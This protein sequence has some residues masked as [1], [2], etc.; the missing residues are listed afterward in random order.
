MNKTILAERIGVEPRSVLAYE[1]GEYAPKDDVLARI[2]R[3]LR[4]PVAFFFGP[5][6]HEPAVDT[7]SFRSMSRMSAAQKCAALGA[8][9]IAFMLN[10]WIEERFQLPETD[11]LDLR[12]EEPEAAASMLRQQWG[13]G[14]RSIKN[15]V[16]LLEAK[17]VRVFSLMEKNV[18]V[19]AFS[20]W[21]GSTPF[22]FLNT[23]KSAEH[24]RFDAAHELGHLVLHRHGGPRGQEAERQAH[25]FA[26]AF[27]MPRSS[28]LA[29]APRL[30]TLA[31]VIQLKR[32]W[33]V[34]AA[35]LV[36][37]LHAVGLLTDWHYR[38]LCIE[39][40][41]RGYRK[42][43]PAGAPREQSEIIEKVLT[44]LRAEG[45]SKSGIAAALNIE[46]EEL[47][48]LLFGLVMTALGGT[49]VTRTAA[50]GQLRVVK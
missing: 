31:H 18:E 44:A 19:D 3:E 46:V 10:D 28:V 4:F 26:S 1:A 50:R 23:Q 7:V 27:L 25:A 41:Q 9:V 38:T 42:N 17:G 49:G 39:M 33:I 35:A 2:G 43:E 15:M 16:H 6:L 37:R 30:A 29:L 11:V 40:S 48:S 12:D 14:E 24:S 47:D 34:S 5:D 21:R 36:V 22:V 20:L 32:Q 13:L 8:G 45:V